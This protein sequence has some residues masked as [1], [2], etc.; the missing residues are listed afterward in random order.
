[1]LF[2]RR[3]NNN[4]LM[5]HDTY[6]YFCLL[7]QPTKSSHTNSLNIFQNL[8]NALLVLI[9]C[10]NNFVL[11]VCL[12][13]CLFEINKKCRNNCNISV[14]ISKVKKPSGEIKASKEPKITVL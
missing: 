10:S 4:D 12:P 7:S 3:D 1:M 11:M 8:S 2:L 9:Y 5:N 13:I 6:I 14:Q